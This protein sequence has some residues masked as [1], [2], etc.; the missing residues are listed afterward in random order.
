MAIL[1]VEAIEDLL[2]VVEH[3]VNVVE[4]EQESIGIVRLGVEHWLN[5]VVAVAR[6]NNVMLPKVQLFAT[7]G[8]KKE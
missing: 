5:D 3:I 7:A 2:M 1:V 6:E 8:L 4:A